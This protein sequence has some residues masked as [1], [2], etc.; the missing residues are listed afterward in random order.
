VDIAEL[1]LDP[2]EL[3][4]MVP[5]FMDTPESE[6]SKVAAK[7]VQ[8]T[9]PAGKT[10]IRQGEKGETLYLIVRGVVR[11]SRETSGDEHDLAML[12]AGDFFG[13]MALLHGTPR[14]ATCRAVTPTAVYELRR[15][16][17]DD[18][19][20]VCPSIQ[21]ALEKADKKRREELDAF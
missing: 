9:I 18:V 2:T 19:C 13:E 1:R 3:L 8:R 14:V 16:D 7:L 20:R 5:F 10:I 17:F 12:I 21:A 11:V 6:F 4:R 15:K